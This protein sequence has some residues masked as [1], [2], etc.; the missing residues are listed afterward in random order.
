[1]KSHGLR[2]LSLPARLWVPCGEAPKPVGTQVR[3]GEPLRAGG[4]PAPADGTIVGTETRA[5]L[6]HPPAMTVVLETQPTSA[7]DGSPAATADSVRQMLSGLGAGQPAVAMDRLEAAGVSADRW[8]SPNLL[9]QMR[10]ILRRPIAS[11]LCNA[12]D[13]DPVLPLQRSVIDAHALEVAAGVAALAKLTGAA[14]SMIA[15]AEN[16][17]AA[18]VATLRA[19]AQAAPVRLFPL[20]DEYP[21]ANPSLLV[22]RSVGRRLSPGRTPTEAGVLLLDAAAALS[23]GRCFLFDE[24]MTTV[25]FGVF[26]RRNARA[27]L[28]Y[29]TV[30]TPL[31]D[32]LAGT[33]VTIDS[34]DLRA[35][36]FLRQIAAPRDAIVGGAELTVFAAQPQEPMLPSACL[37]C[38][39]CVDAC[40][41]RIHPAGLL[42][43]AQQQDPALADRYGLSACIDCG[44]CSYV[45]PSRLP[46]LQA[47]RLLRD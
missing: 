42:E 12:L 44:I 8:T 15:V 25:P 33:D 5:M 17:P 6:G 19:A 21:L 36:H 9:E 28:L 4:T 18:G 7:A 38:G 16:T 47:I 31:N 40:P 11:V 3:R 20:P 26:D 14:G 30:G 46:L 23:V 22:R 45:C 43:A 41:A 34:A 13:L 2:T 32:V 37:R 27:H 29:V 1:M 39:F 24:A 35:G 10:Q